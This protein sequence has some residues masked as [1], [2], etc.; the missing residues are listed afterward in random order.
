VSTLQFDEIKQRQRA[1]WDA[2]APGWKK[3]E[4]KFIHNLQPLTDMLVKNAGIKPG[5]SVL[6]LA[7]GT[8][9]PA[10][11]IAKIVGPSGRVV[12]VDIAPG[13]IAVAKERMAAQG[14]KNVTFQLNEHD[15]LPALQ[16]NT[17]DVATC[18]LGLMFMPDPVRMLKAI[19][20]TLKPGGKAS[21][22]VWGPPEKAPFFTVPMKAV[23]KQLP[24]LKPVPPGTPGGPFGIP[25]QEMLGGIFTKA[26]FSNFNAHTANVTVWEA[27]SPEEYYEAATETAGPIVQLLSTMAPEKKKV[28]REELVQTLRGMFPSGPVSLGGE[29]ILGTGTKT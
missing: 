24:D 17:F 29:A 27:N 6:D 26:G 21:V 13:M 22:V 2:S 28:V 20:R 1:Q 3:W 5:Y 9:E 18:R 16:D 8:G 23:A 25:N 14:L 11:T 7:C 10:L 4:R 12:G 15:D 19:R